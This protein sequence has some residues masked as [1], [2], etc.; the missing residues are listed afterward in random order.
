MKP[1]VLLVQLGEEDEGDTFDDTF[2]D[3]YSGLCNE[4]EEHYTVIKAKSLTT[5]YLAH[6]KAIIVTDGGLSK[7]KNQNF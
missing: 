3:L 5:E 1:Q 4:I 7:K 2:D 6:S